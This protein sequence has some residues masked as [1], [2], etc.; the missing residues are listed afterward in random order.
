LP[1]A[2]RRS[3]EIDTLPSQKPTSL[4][5]IEPEFIAAAQLPH[6]NPKPSPPGTDHQ[7]D[8]DRQQHHRGENRPSDDN[9]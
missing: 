5:R 7:G 9:P 6:A 3:F 8:C 4:G 1:S 2:S